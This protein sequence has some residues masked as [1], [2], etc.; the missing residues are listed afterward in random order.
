MEQADPSN[1]YTAILE[2]IKQYQEIEHNIVEVQQ[3]EHLD[4]LRTNSGVESFWRK[5]VCV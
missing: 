4:T 5:G 3:A 2:A 1:S